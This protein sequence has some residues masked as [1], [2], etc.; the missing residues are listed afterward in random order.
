MR[1]VVLIVGTLDTK[2]RE[3]AYLKERITGN[4]CD[5]VIMDVG[6]FPQSK[7]DPDIT[8]DQVAGAAGRSIREILE[9]KDR[10]LAV[11]TMTEGGA[12]L[13]LNVLFE[14]PDFSPG[15]CHRPG[16]LF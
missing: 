13:A 2:V 12:V 5:T 8:R 16:L 7:L 10:K 9:L 15:R 14:I 6:V 3:V 11:F 1:P 4:D